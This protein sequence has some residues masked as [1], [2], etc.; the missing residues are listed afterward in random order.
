M[1]FWEGNNFAGMF[2]G[3][4]K[5]DRIHG[6]GIMLYST[7]LKYIGERYEGKRH[8]EGT[9][10]Y[11]DGKKYTGQWENDK[12]HG[13]G[14]MVYPD[15]RRY[16]GEWKD[17]NKHGQGT[18]FYADGN[19]YSGEWENDEI[20]TPSS[21]VF[22]AKHKPAEMAAP[23]EYGSEPAQAQ[24]E[25]SQVRAKADAGA[26]K[27]L[28]ENNKLPSSQAAAQETRSPSLETQASPAS[29]KEQSAR[30]IKWRI[31]ELTKQLVEKEE[32]QKQEK[33]PVKLLWVWNMV[34]TALLLA[35][36]VFIWLNIL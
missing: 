21:D 20:K 23:N 30:D 10:F 33:I 31:E 14:T 17:D 32:Q 15:G 2:V 18:I 29:E 27:I 28:E 8:G 12:R 4:W 24:P 5:D 26:D 25:K 13:Q 7:G 19:E 3:E 11:N 22:T 9:M 35:L 1:T 16:S 34:T 36:I 6:Q